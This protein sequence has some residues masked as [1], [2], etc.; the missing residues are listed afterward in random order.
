MRTKIAATTRLT[1]I[2]VNAPIP[3]V[4]QYTISGDGAAFRIVIA[5]DAARHHSTDGKRIALKNVWENVNL[6]VIRLSSILSAILRPSRHSARATPKVTITENSC[7]FKPGLSHIAL[8]LLAPSLLVAQIDFQ[9]KGYIEYRGFEF[10]QTTSNDSANFIGEALIRYDV[11]YGLAPG[12]R[13]TGGTETRSDTHRQTEREFEL[14]WDDRGLK[15]PNFSIRRFSV[16][17]NRGPIT[18]EAGKQVIRW[19]KTAILN[20]TDRFAP[21]DYLSVVDSDVLAVSAARAKY[22]RAS[23]SIEIVIQPFFTPSRMPLLNQ[24][25]TPAPQPVNDLGNRFPGGP[26][27]GARWDHS[28]DSY[29]VA[30]SFFDG[31]N[32]LPSFTT[33]IDFQRFFP[34]MR[35]YGA[36]AAIPIGGFT[37][38]GE[39]GYFTSST[40]QTDEYL[41]YVI[42]L[43]R[44]TGD[45]SFTG[46]Y[47][48]EAVTAERGQVS[49]APDRGLARSF[50]GRTS[51]DIDAKRG[52]ALD[53]AVRQN[54]DGLWLRSE[55]S[56]KWSSHWSGTVGFTLLRGEP[57][58]FLGQYRRNSFFNLSV[59]YSF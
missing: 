59:R 26:Q 20:P 28:D 40:R 55:Y 49:F 14:N 10:P 30:L 15:R 5:S 44:D 58:D 24:R 47:A 31:Y 17:Y 42:Q 27:W 11:E 16:S 45:W 18:L 3:F 48:G 2:I 36:D 56:E 52:V 6:S 46:G 53:T 37:I 32:H 50:L 7:W 13:L 34:K 9:Q 43:E 4:A 1:L 41:L 51:Y 25:W 29:D 54:G 38:K 19:G 23:D 33:Q 39:A 35:M 22:E 8:L 21:R 12:L 57:A